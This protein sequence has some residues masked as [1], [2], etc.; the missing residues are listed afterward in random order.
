MLKKS[1]ALMLA[2]M[3]CMAAGALFAPTAPAVAESALT[4]EEG[5]PTETTATDWL[6]S[7]HALWQSLWGGP[8]LEVISAATC[9]ENPCGTN[10]CQP[11]LCGCVEEDPCHENACDPEACGEGGGDG[12]GQGG[13]F[14]P[15]G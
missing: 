12:G 9:D 7:L 8:Q 10:P 14:D 5:S 4:H 15:G 2:V 3:V 11:E 1:L 6:S 13:R